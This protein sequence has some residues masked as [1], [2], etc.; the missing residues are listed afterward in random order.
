MFLK[1]LSDVCPIY[2]GPVST[3]H[4]IAEKTAIFVNNLMGPNI[5][6]VANLLILSRPVEISLQATPKG[7]IAK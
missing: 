3:L 5:L 1:N 7:E 4:L 6:L 2:P